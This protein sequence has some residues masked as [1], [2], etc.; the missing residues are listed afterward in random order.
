MHLEAK[1]IKYVLGHKPCPLTGYVHAPD[2]SVRELLGEIQ[3]ERDH[4][5]RRQKAKSCIIQPVYKEH[6]LYRSYGPINRA[7]NIFCLFWF[8]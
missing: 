8:F 6:L 4:T 2:E 3:L 5:L 7:S 1:Y